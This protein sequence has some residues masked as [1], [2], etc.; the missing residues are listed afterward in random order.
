[1]TIEADENRW[2]SLEVRSMSCGKHK[3]TCVPCA[4]SAQSGHHSHGHLPRK[5]GFPP[6]E[7]N[8]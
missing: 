8:T 1:M 5:T 4:S 3:Q 6:F 7:I 2:G